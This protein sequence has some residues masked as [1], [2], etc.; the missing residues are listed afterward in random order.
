MAKVKQ[1]K[2]KTA[3]ISPRGVKVTVA[4]ESVQKYLDRGYKQAGG[5]AKPAAVTDASAGEGKS[6]TSGGK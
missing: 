4:A 6:R 3:L 5:R 1:A 2:E